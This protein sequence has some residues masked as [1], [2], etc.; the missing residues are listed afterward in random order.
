MDAVADA[1][2]DDVV[3]ACDVPAFADWAV[4]EDEQPYIVTVL[5]TQIAS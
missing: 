5:P 4:V 1:G 3:A 2:S